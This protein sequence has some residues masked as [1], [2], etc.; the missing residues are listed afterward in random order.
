[1]IEQATVCHFDRGGAE[2]GATFWFVRLPDGYLVD[3]G[4]SGLSKDRAELL[5]LLVNR[6]EWT[7][8]WNK[9]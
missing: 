5:A 2:G 6:S 1:M 8:G 9:P 4:F 7:V 3:C